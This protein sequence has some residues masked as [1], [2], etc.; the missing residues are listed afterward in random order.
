MIFNYAIRKVRNFQLLKEEEEGLG[1]DYQ[2]T[3][4]ILKLRIR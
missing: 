2:I 1:L 3:S 4:I